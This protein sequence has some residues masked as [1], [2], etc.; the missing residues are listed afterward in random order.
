MHIFLY[1]LKEKQNLN[2][3]WEYMSI[4]ASFSDSVHPPSCYCNAYMEMFGLQ[5][6]KLPV[7]ILPHANSSYSY[8]TPRSQTSVSFPF[9]LSTNMQICS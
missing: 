3:K 6:M 7:H 9:S 1:F 8:I 5:F 4:I 2:S